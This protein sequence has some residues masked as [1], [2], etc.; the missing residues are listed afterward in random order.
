M[1]AT[2]LFVHRSDVCFNM[3]AKPSGGSDHAGG[4]R[5]AGTATQAWIFCKNAVNQNISVSGASASATRSRDPS[6]FPTWQLGFLEIH[7]TGYDEAH[8]QIRPTLGELNLR[9]SGK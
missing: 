8:F 7:T 2:N 5:A 9:L 3:Q 4:R 1:R 6:Y